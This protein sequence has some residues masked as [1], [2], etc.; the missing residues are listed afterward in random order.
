MHE[1]RLMSSLDKL[2]MLFVW[3]GLCVGLA[4]LWGAALTPNA[5][6]IDQA[7]VWLPQSPNSAGQTLSRGRIAFVSE[8]NGNPEIYVMD[9]S[10]S[11]LRRL[12]RNNAVDD[13]PTWSSDGQRIA[14]VSERDGNREIYTMNSDGSALT[15]L[16]RNRARDDSPTWSPDGARIAFVSERDGLPQIY[17][18]HADGGEVRR[19]TQTDSP[20]TQ[21]VWS[22][23][24]KRIAFVSEQDGNPEIYVMDADGANPRRL[25]DDPAPDSAPRWSP[26]GKRLLFVSE[27][28]G[29]RLQIFSMTSEG[30]D[31]TLIA[32]T[33]AADVRN[34]APAWSPDG[35]W[36]A[37]TTDRDG[38]LE[39]YAVRTDGT[40]LRNLTR[41][42]TDDYSPSWSAGVTGG[43]LSG[44]PTATPTPL[45]GGRQIGMRR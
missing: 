24:G 21:P 4:L 11:N 22:P 3:L 26:D 14:F 45:G 38:N 10:G 25:T 2:R 8:R 16:T 33:N 44:R 42:R 32:T 12:T 7:V 43:T 40:G 29:A 9:A 19:L 31:V 1:A 5:W 39:I 28:E 41:S 6:L 13:S 20:K 37:F 15:R 23:D 30:E 27:R 34:F 36:I 17:V 18:M 35:L